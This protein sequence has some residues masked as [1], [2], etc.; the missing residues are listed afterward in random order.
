[1]SAVNH[2]IGAQNY[3]ANIYAYVRPDSPSRVAFRALAAQEMPPAL[4]VERSLPGPV[5]RVNPLTSFQR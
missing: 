1:M 2:E 4:V 3:F 5:R